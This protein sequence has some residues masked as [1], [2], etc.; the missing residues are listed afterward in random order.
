MGAPE[1]ERSGAKRGGGRAQEGECME[2]KEIFTF[3]LGGITAAGALLCC[4]AALG[5]FYTAAENSTVL[6]VATACV[7]AGLL[8]DN[9]FKENKYEKLFKACGL[10]IKDIKGEKMPKIIKQSKR[11][12]VTTLI[13]HLP[14]GL[15]QKQ[16]EQKKQ[17]LEQGLNSKIE[18]GFNKNLILKLINMDLQSNYKYIFEEC[19]GPLQ[20]YCGN[21]HEGKFILDIE[22]APHMIVAGETNSGKSSL[23]RNMVLSLV[24]NSYN[25]EIHLIDFQAVELGIFE[26]C[27]KVR[28]YGETPDD[29]EKLLNEMADEN[30]RRL[31]LFRSVKNKIYIQSLKVWNEKFPSRALP[32]KVIV[33]DEFSRLSEEE[34]K[35]VLEKFRSRV[36]M[37]RKVGIHYIV[38]MQ[39]PDV[40]CI[41]GSIKANMPTRAAFKT[42]SQVDS[43]VILDQGGA[44]QIKQQ[45]RFF[46]KYCGEFKEVQALYLE[47]EQVRNFLKK[48]NKF[49][50]REDI[51]AEKKEQMK[52]L[53]QKCINPYLKVMK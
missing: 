49:K 43:E 8:L 30:D 7:T 52:A 18:F 25:L 17:E 19:T 5:M 51:A 32:H 28:S 34:Y 42:F 15:S 10:V 41:S 21:S 24:L 45:G 47:N 23:L 26:N 12:G 6:P 31:K 9:M 1:A 3:R 33:I 39:R 22:K 40:K 13:V 38:A 36:A 48:A 53:R 16:F 2:K 14:E 50:S 27:K 35:F 29:F 37:D 4:N 44:E 11:D 46:I 20:V